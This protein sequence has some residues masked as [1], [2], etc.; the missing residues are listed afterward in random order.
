MAPL[1]AMALFHSWLW[2]I[3]FMAMAHSIHG[4]GPIPFMAMAPFHSWPWPQSIHGHSP[5]PFMAKSLMHGQGSVAGAPYNCTWQ[6]VAIYPESHSPG[7]TPAYISRESIESG[8][9]KL[10]A[11]GVVPGGRCRR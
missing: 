8:N 4:H 10:L 6:N 9:Q 11:L 1:M 2:R 3:P 7:V 5:I